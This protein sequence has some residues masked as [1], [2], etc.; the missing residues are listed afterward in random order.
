M[1]DE[2][3]AK[4]QKLRNE[5]LSLREI[6]KIVGY[7]YQTVHRY[8][9]PSANK[10]HYTKKAIDKIVYTGI[11][12]WMHKNK[13]NISSL[14]REM[15]N[16]TTLPYLYG[17]LYG[18]RKPGMETIE[19]ILAV[20]GMTYE[21]AFV[22]DEASETYTAE[23][24]RQTIPTTIVEEGTVPTVIT[25]VTEAEILHPII[26]SMTEKE[27]RSHPAISRS[28]LFNFRK[29]PLHFKYARE[30]PPEPTAALIFGQAFHKF[31][32]EPDGFGEEFVV[33]PDV[34]RRTK[35]GREQWAAFQ[36]AANGKQIITSAD[37]ST[38]QGMRESL[39]ANKYV[40]F[41]I[42]KSQH[43]LPL[44]WTDE[45]SGEEC[46][47]RLDMFLGDTSPRIVA[48]LKSCM[49]ASKDEF[50]RS[51]YKH[52]Y[53]LQVYQ[54]LEGVS[55]NF[56]M[57]P[58]PIKPDTFIFVAVEKTPPYAINVMAADADMIS[59]GEQLF[60]DF[61]GTYHECKTTGDWYSYNGHFGAIN[62]IGLPDYVRKEFE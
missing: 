1:T 31:V 11:R 60:R 37:M 28:E 20:T 56:G 21:Q 36:E 48:D 39:M 29:T 47:C 52:G 3:I 43:E 40:R 30:H 5:G 50:S 61:I 27:Y 49:S 54:Y 42:E 35:A 12:E 2:E 8:T 15:G 23:E 45:L 38:I 62:R 57:A 26:T 7:S 10:R 14:A 9:K 51:A 33:A 24:T 41:L 4:I 46:K 22:Q 55:H 18:K 25:S 59:R 16:S 58:D 13:T 6:G 32:L 44:F 17:Y 19:K 34:D 53:D